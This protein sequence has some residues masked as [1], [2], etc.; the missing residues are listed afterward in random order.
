MMEP[1]EEFGVIYKGIEDVDRQYID[2]LEV[3]G[4][5]TMSY[6]DIFDKAVEN[7]AGMWLQISESIETGKEISMVKNWDLDTGVNTA[8]GQ[9]TFWGNIQEEV[10]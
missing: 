4:K 1:L 10:A 5:Q 9:I 3:P 2:N 6:D 7:V 8:S